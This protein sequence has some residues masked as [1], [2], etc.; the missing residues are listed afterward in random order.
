MVNLYEVLGVEPT[1]DLKDIR[2]SYRKLAKANHPDR[3]GDPEVLRRVQLAYDVLSN[4]ARRKRYDETGATDDPATREHQAG[5]DMMAQ[6][7][8]SIL[9][10]MTMGNHSPATFDVVAELRVAIVKEK[11]NASKVVAET[12]KHRKL[13]KGIAERLP[14]DH[15]LT[16]LITG[17]LA[18]IDRNTLG[19]RNAVAGCESALKLL[20]GVTYKLDRY[21]M[22]M[23]EGADGINWKVLATKKYCK[24]GEE[25]T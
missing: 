9:K 24:E 18:V 13:I 22:G 16:G 17:Q 7:V 12:E 1:A 19:A 5:I 6:F 10:T 3:G 21:G 11:A 23:F 8:P 2:Y 15:P 20:E 14:P 4:P 25:L